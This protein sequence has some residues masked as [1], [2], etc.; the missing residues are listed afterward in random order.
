MW[1]RV[2]SFSKGWQSL[3]TKGDHS[4]RLHRSGASQFLEFATLNGPNQHELRGRRNVNDQAWHHVVAVHDDSGKQLYVDGR[5]DAT[6]KGVP[7]ILS[8]EHLV[9]I[10]ENDEKGGLY[11]HGLIDDVR[12]YKRA[13]TPLDVRALVL[14]KK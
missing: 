10:G 8:V 14:L 13:L 1:I 9:L 6:A 7:K 3:I 5:L 11:F 4:W 2:A 12:V